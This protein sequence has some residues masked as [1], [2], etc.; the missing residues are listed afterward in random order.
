M[1]VGG[2]SAAAGSCLLG[3]GVAD[4]GG[5]GIGKIGMCSV[6]GGGGL[7]ICRL[8]EKLGMMCLSMIFQITK[9]PRFVRCPG[10]EF[11]KCIGA[12]PCAAVL[13]LVF[14]LRLDVG[15]FKILS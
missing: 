7:G 15:R 13:E 9:G 3:S 14:F 11:A 4:G 12:L 5:L 6:A 2:K 1:R 8:V 10:T